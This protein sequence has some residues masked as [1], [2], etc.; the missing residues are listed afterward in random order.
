MAYYMGV[1]LCMVQ[2]ICSTHEKSVG[3]APVTEN[4]MNEQPTCVRA[5]AAMKERALDI[6][7]RW[8]VPNGP[9]ENSYVPGPRDLGASLEAEW[10]EVVRTEGVAALDEFLAWELEHLARF[11]EAI[12]QK[13]GVSVAGG[14]IDYST[15]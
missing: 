1:E 7:S 8:W 2:G 15:S 5:L 4:A 13:R 14:A 10:G 6:N 11:V 9:H 3:L 12:V